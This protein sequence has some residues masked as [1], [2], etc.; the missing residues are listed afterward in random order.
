[1]YMYEQQFRFL[2]DVFTN[3]CVAL[4]LHQVPCATVTRKCL[5]YVHCHTCLHA[6]TKA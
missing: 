4:W 3:V 1:M 2:I 6:A 5:D